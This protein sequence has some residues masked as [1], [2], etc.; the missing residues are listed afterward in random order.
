MRRR[1]LKHTNTSC[2]RN[3]KYSTHCPHRT[4]LL[5]VGAHEHCSSCKGLHL[6][7]RITAGATHHPPAWHSSQFLASLGGHR[8]S[9][10]GLIRGRYSTLVKT[11][12]LQVC[13]RT[14]RSE[15]HAFISG[16]LAGWVEKTRTWQHVAMQTLHSP[17][18]ARILGVLYIVEPL[19]STS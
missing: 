19:H 10:N 9:E 15:I 5:S 6:R 11:P 7:K 16:E 1:T 8:L 14:G 17:N 4:D 12:S 3:L 13:G 2:E 18:C